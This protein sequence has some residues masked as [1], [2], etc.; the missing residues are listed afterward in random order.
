MRANSAIFGRFVNERGF[1]PIATHK[2]GCFATTTKNGCEIV[3]IDKQKL[4]YVSAFRIGAKTESSMAYIHNNQNFK[5]KKG[6]K[7]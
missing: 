1:A 7:K 5:T 3:L 2:N 4:R 6:E